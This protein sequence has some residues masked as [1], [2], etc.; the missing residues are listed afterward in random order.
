MINV[1]DNQQAARAAGIRG[2]PAL[3]VMKDGEVL[4]QIESRDRESMV[5]EFRD[6]F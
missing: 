3:L 1:D 2:I 4:G 5:E 6:F